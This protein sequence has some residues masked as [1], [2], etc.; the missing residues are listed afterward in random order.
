MNKP[1][2]AP[3][4]FVMFIST[5]FNFYQVVTEFN[6]ET[7]IPDSYCYHKSTGH[8][9]TGDLKIMTDSRIRSFV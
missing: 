3:H 1:L 2:I 6:M 8:I 7:T 5:I 4:H 9:F